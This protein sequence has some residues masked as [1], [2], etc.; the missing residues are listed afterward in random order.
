MNRTWDYLTFS[1]YAHQCKNV[2]E[3]SELLTKY[4]FYHKIEN[5]FQVSSGNEECYGRLKKWIT[6]TATYTE[7][8]VKVQMF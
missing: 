8:G 2:Q 3:L 7:K 5:E 4:G 1:S 6:Y